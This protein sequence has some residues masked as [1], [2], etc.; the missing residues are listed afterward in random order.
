ML[1]SDANLAIEPESDAGLDPAVA[2]SEKM[3]DIAKNQQWDSLGV[4]EETRR[5]FLEKFFS[6]PHA[7]ALHQQ[8]AAHIRYILQLDQQ[9][10]ALA[11][12][13]HQAAAD[14][15]KQQSQARRADHAYTTTQHPAE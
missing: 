14:G 13:E 2:L 5:L 15:I 10:I 6:N 1:S 3:L 4:I 12:I 8:I 9:I 11:E 7:P